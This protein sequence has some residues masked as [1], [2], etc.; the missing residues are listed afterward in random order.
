MGESSGL[1]PQA[2]GETWS[3][4]GPSRRGPAQLVECVGGGS[5]AQRRGRE[6][7][8]G[9]VPGGPLDVFRKLT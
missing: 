7:G 5:G 1:F 2:S 3:V 4:A 8:E 6:E 9:E